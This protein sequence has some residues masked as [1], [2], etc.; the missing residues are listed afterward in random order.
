[1]ISNA[2]RAVRSA[3]ATGGSGGG[4]LA[5]T[6]KSGFVPVRAN[7]A[8]GPAPAP[9]LHRR[10]STAPRALGAHAIVL[11]T[12]ACCASGCADLHYDRIRL[13]QPKQ[14]Y[15]RVLPADAARTTDIGVAWLETDMTGRI[16]AVVV[17]AARDR[18][19]AAKFHAAWLQRNYGWKT[20]TGFSLRGELNPKLADLSATGPI[21]TARWIAERLTSYQGEKSATQAHAWVAA[22]LARFLQR[23]PHMADQVRTPRVDPAMLDRVPPGGVASVTV[24]E[25]GVYHFEYR[26]GI[27]PPRTGR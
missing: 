6:S 23:W 5:V 1:M 20:E 27:Q 19:A 14:E 4:E 25:A 12:I 24:D 17:L 11:L 21:D 2:A 26:Q 9:L 7:A 15:E 16:D 13:G 10:P 18:S 3:T 8:G 22:G